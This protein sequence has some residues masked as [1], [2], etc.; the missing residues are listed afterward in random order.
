MSPA[1]PSWSDRRSAVIKYDK[2]S[3]PREPFGWIDT[4]LTCF[5][6]GWA[7]E[8]WGK[9]WLTRI[10]G[11]TWDE[12]EYGRGPYGFLGFGM[13]SRTSESCRIN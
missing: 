7:L 5:P 11:E 10:P 13:V 8:P 1:F 6:P 9:S 3:E 12:V 4:D 2:C